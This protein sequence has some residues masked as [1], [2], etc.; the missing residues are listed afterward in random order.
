MNPS[1]IH[2]LGVDLSDQFVNF[3]SDP[4]H[5]ISNCESSLESH[6]RVL[7]KTYPHVHVVC[8]ATGRC[9]HALQLVT[10][11]LGIPISVVNPRQARD[12]A[13]S[14]GRL[15]KTD[16]IDA[17][18]L[19][20]YGRCLQPSPTVLAGKALRKMRD[21]LV[22]RSAL[23]EDYRSWQCRARQ[24]DP[25]AQRLCEQHMKSINADIA[26]VEGALRRLLERKDAVALAER[27]QAMCLVCSIAEKTSWMLIAE[28]PELG[29]CNRREIAKLC[30][31]APLNHDSGKMRGQRHIAHGRTPVRRALYQAAVVAAQHN[32]HLSGYYRRLR[33][34]GKPAKVAYIAVARKLVV[35]LNRILADAPPM[36][37]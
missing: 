15:E 19:E 24:I 1:A 25:S 9:H 34:A 32:E 5:P 3:S 13:R 10:A 18:V 4:Q 16:A 33:E 30:G 28:L 27:M 11:K 8:E 22:V 37:V 6:L 35:F 26:K 14:L 17:A 23:V 12:F 20:H 31:L 7:R 21:L 29:R 2:Y 36:H